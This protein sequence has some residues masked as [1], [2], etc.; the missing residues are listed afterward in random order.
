[1]CSTKSL[2]AGDGEIIAQ[3]YKERVVEARLRLRRLGLADRLSRDDR[4]L[5]AWRRG[6]PRRRFGKTSKERRW[7][8]DI[9]LAHVRFIAGALALA[10]VVAV[11]AP[12]TRAAAESRS[13]RRRAR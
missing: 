8:G 6:M 5:I 13:I 7:H 2:L 12:A 10:F 4:D 3:I 9:L 11:A 1:M